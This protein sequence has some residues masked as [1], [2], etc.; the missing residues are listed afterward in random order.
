M[1]DL[2]VLDESLLLK[3]LANAVFAKRFPF[4]R[5]AARKLT[6]LRQRTSGTCTPCQRKRQIRSLELGTLKRALTK[7]PAQDRADF[8]ALLQARKV[9]F[10]YRNDKDVPVKVVF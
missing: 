1:R 9:K 10:F 8:K 3:I 5:D 6:Q 4:L 2:V 7:L